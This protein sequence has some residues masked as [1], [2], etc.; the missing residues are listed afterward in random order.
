MRY[1]AGQ[2][3]YTGTKVHGWFDHSMKHFIPENTLGIVMEVHTFDK[4]EPLYMV[5]FSKEFGNVMCRESQL[6][7]M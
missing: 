3:V 7:L 1:F 5:Q 2:N 4:Q 6:K